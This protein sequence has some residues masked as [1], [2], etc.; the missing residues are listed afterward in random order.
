[1]TCLNTQLVN[2]KE[3]DAIQDWII[4][5]HRHTCR[6][7]CGQHFSLY[8][9][10]HILMQ[11]VGL[12]TV[13]HKEANCQHPVLGEELFHSLLTPSRTPS[14]S[15]LLILVLVMQ[16]FHICLGH[17]DPTCLLHVVHCQEQTTA[18]NCRYHNIHVL[19]TSKQPNK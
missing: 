12:F 6:P 17:L 18:I 10:P 9:K 3:T 8:F 2:D 14:F 16:L 4:I 15:L 19:V 7:S 11:H 13:S 5:S 1:M